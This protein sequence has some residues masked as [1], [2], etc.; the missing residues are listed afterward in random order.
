MIERRYSA[1]RSLWWEKMVDLK[2]IRGE[3]GLSQVEFAE[4]LA[5]SVRTVQSCEQR[6]RNPSANVQKAALLLMMVYRNQADFGH[7]S[8]WESSHCATELRDH[9]IAFWSRQGHLCWFLTGTICGGQR[10]NSWKEKL[11]RCAKCEFFRKLL[12][13]DIPFETPLA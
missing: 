2:A 3:L 4:L 9:C 7:Q 6:W 10:T 1:V 5:V 13:D 12:H 11:E 8:C